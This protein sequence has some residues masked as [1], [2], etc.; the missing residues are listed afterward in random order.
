MSETDKIFNFIMGLKP[1]VKTKLYEQSVQSLST[2]YAVSNDCLILIAMKPQRWGRIEHPQVVKMR[3]IDQ[4][5]LE[6]GIV[7]APKMRKR[8]TN[9]PNREVGLLGGDH[10]NRLVRVKATTTV[11]L[12]M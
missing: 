11:L 6:V 5:P 2:A 12:H 10:T 4:T 3:I 7:I 9:P 1:W 8:N